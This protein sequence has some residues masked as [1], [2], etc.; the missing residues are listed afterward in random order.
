VFFVNAQNVGEK[1]S[2]LVAQ[3]KPQV[4]ALDMSRVPDLEY[5]ALQMLMQGEQRFAEQG[6]IVWLVGLNP[7]VLEVV[8][9]SELHQRLGPERLLFNA[10]AA[11]ERYKTLVNASV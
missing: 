1:I 7:G 2:A 9:R 11:I 8:R 6:T 10:R 4:V 5:S 3:Y